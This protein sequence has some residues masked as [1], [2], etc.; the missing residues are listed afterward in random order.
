[1]TEDF[2][3]LSLKPMI[4]EI[5]DRLKKLATEDNQ[6]KNTFANE[7]KKLKNNLEGKNTALNYTLMAISCLGPMTLVIIAGLLITLEKKLEKLKRR[8][9]DLQIP[10]NTNNE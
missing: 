6:I 3:N 4:E 1:M 8:L 5:V 7:D 9:A 2:V 10:D